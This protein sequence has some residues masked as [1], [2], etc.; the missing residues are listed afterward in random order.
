ML[1]AICRNRAENCGV[2][3]TEE[4]VIHLEGE[5]EGISLPLHLDVREAVKGCFV[6]GCSVLA[7][8]SALCRGY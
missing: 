8:A 4:S 6:L 2:E 5:G 7:D 1:L 3:D